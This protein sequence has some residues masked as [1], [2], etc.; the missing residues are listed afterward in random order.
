MG[1]A[2]KKSQVYINMTER[3]KKKKSLCAQH[4]VFSIQSVYESEDLSLWCV[5][6]VQSH[7]HLLP[8]SV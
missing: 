1:R 4:C 8:S 3:K 2:E 6:S 5:Y 7:Q